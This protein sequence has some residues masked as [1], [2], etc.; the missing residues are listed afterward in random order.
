MRLRSLAPLA[1]MLT[2]STVAGAA[3]F[4]AGVGGPACPMNEET[5]SFAATGFCADSISG[6][7]GLGADLYQGARSAANQAGLR[8]AASSTL[9]F[10]DDAGVL[11]PGAADAWAEWIYDDFVINGSGTTILT[12]LNVYVTGI[13]HG[14]GNTDSQGTLT[15]FV[16]GVAEVYF[17]IELDGQYAGSGYAFAA[18]NN[19][20]PLFQASDMMAGWN[21]GLVRGIGDQVAL[22]VGQAFD[23]RVV[24]TASAR[25]LVRVMGTPADSSDTILAGSLG[26][27]DF[28]GT[29]TFPTSGS[30]FNLPP[31]FTVSSPSAGI[32]DNQLVPEPEVVSLLALGAI[33][34]LGRRRRSCVRPS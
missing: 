10:N 15:S 16:N 21:G 14:D 27:A 32:V 20:A 2:A 12:S 17:E 11:Q 3:T 5:N 7:G 13:L 8:A 1:L 33:G 19:G 29:L 25:N 24:I 28:F 4:R 9:I 30:V 26:E 23:V 34:V 6:V 31:G 22:P 18:Y